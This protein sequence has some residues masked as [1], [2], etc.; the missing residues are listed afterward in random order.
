MIYEWKFEI[1]NIKNTI[2]SS[3]PC[4]YLQGFKIHDSLY[5]G[6]YAISV[7]ST[8]TVRIFRRTAGTFAKDI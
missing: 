8:K 7:V 4:Y 2:P 5:M 6:N 1:V 3:L